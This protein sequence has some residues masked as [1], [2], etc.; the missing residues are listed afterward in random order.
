MTD[1]NSQSHASNADTRRHVVQFYQGDEQAL[2]RN[3]ARFFHDGLICGQGVV[4]IA[5]AGRR[6]AIVRE[7]GGLSV[8]VDAAVRS[9]SAVLLDAEETLGRLMLDDRPDAQRFEWVIGSVLRALRDVTGSRDVRAYGEM[10]GILW[11]AGRRADALRLEELWN[12]LIEREELELFC[13]YPIDVF[14][15]AFGITEMDAVLCAHTHLVSADAERALEA[16]VE[17]A[18]DDVLGARSDLL[19]PLM[20]ANYRPSWAVLPRGE[21]IVLWLRNNLPGTADEILRRAQSYYRACG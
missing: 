12:G 10:V 17:R 15:A 5:T 3:V 13:G 2:T 11:E 7:L 16:A 18:M 4:V 1:P 9:G 8:D 21:A 20:K 14:G 6:A 19:R